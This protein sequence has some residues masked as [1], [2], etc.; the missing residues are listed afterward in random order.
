MLL[1]LGY[2]VLTVGAVGVAYAV[3]HKLPE[4]LYQGRLAP[5]LNCSVCTGTQ[6]GL[7]FA[8]VA[9]AAWGLS[10]RQLPLPWPL[11]VLGVIGFAPHIGLLS[12]LVQRWL[13]LVTAIEER[14]K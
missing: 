5:L 3:N 8:G 9:L 6:V 11:C 7:L 13:N 10:Y 12:M 14:Q 2:L 1:I 4:R